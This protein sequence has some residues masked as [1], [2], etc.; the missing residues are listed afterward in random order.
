AGLSIEDQSQQTHALYD[1]PLAVERVRA[2]R[3]AIDAEAPG[4]LLVARTE[5]LLGERISVAEAIDRLVALAGAGADCLFAPGLR[6]PTDIATAVRAVSPK[7]LTLIAP[8]S[9]THSEAA[10]LGVRRLSVGGGLARIAYGALI[11][12][13]REIGE[14]SFA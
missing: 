4:V 1:L 7:P 8:P 2:A 9:L 5:G 10:D 13:A 14:G 6:E 11:E 12:A 3:A